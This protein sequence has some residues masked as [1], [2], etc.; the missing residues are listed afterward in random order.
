MLWQC[1]PQLQS[2][3]PESKRL[4]LTASPQLVVS[5][6][7]LPPNK[8]DCSFVRRLFQAPH[9]PPPAA[10][11]TELVVAPRATPDPDSDPD[12]RTSRDDLRPS[13]V[14][15]TRSLLP[16]FTGKPSSDAAVNKIHAQF[17][18]TDSGVIRHRGVWSSSRLPV[19]ARAL[20]RAPPPL[21]HPQMPANKD[22]QP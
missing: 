8:G 7:A 5:A 11:E 16:R 2:A 20:Q 6:E 15:T 12:A 22:G 17:S 10:D 21:E 18:S 3:Q 1:L 14:P 13:P 9:P 19:P 4:D